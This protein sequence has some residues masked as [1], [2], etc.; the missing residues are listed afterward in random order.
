M[1]VKKLND[2]H[3]LNFLKLRARDSTYP[4]KPIKYKDLS[5]IYSF[6][7]FSNQE[8]ITDSASGSEQFA[9]NVL[10]SVLKHE[11]TLSPTKRT[12]AQDGKSTILKSAAKPEHKVTLLKILNHKES[13]LK[14]ILGAYRN[15]PQKTGDIKL[16]AVSFYLDG[17]TNG[18]LEYIKEDL[19]IINNAF[20]S[21]I[22]KIKQRVLYERIAGYI[23]LSMVNEQY[24]PYVHAL[25]FIKDGAI[26]HNVIKDIVDIWAS[27]TEG[28]IYCRAEISAFDYDFLL[29]FQYEIIDKQNQQISN[30]NSPSNKTKSKIEYYLSDVLHPFP[31]AKDP[32]RN[33]SI[34][35]SQISGI[36]RGDE[37][38]RKY[39]STQVL[40]QEDADETK[41]IQKKLGYKKLV[42]KASFHMDYFVRI[43]KKINI[44]PNMH[45]I[46]CSRPPTDKP[47]E[48]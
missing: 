39:K 12:I 35:S 11:E 22:N 36:R 45:A 9:Y 26:N 48:K 40:E 6:I 29:A 2:F 18:N 28:N 15:F 43:A 3:E 17:T 37:S 46:D 32:Y 41:R 4:G 10:E 38:H 33:L 27:F 47:I 23:R 14:K 30:E 24:I 7:D 34:F 16:V 20:A 13:V 21:M 8:C 31:D 44:I 42:D 19:S 1:T 5:N 25:F